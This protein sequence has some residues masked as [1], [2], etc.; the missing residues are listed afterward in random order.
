M[1]IY[2]DKTTYLAE[3]G[4]FFEGNVQIHGDFIVPQRTHF[5]GRLVV[6]GTLEMGPEC[7][8]E[9]AVVCKNAIIGR[10]SRIKGPLLVD[11]NATICDRAHLHSVETGGDLVLRPGVTVGDVKA[12][13]S[14]LIYGK[15]TSGTLVG[16]NVR[17]IGD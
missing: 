14:V 10:D 6:N 7:S 12:E 1:K 2:K 5:W 4:S 9:G 8:V 16:R 11:E 17:I 3:P 13:N 15:I